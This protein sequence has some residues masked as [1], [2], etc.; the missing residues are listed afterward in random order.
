[1]KNLKTSKSSQ[2]EIMGLVVIILLAIVAMLFVVK[3]VI[4][5]PPQGSIKES[6]SSSQLATNMLNSLL[7]TT[8]SS[9]KGLDFSKLLQDCAAGKSITCSGN[10]DSCTYTQD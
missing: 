10:K 4:N 8:A 9:C 2:M 6:Y 5:K 1:M 3:Y 7:K